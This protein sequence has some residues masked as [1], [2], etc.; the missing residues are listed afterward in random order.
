MQRL[1]GGEHFTLRTI[2]NFIVRL[3]SKIEENAD[4]PV[5]LETVRGS[6]TASIRDVLPKLQNR[7]V[8]VATLVLLGTC[9]RAYR[10]AS[11]RP[12]ACTYGPPSGTA[13]AAAPAGGGLL[14]LRALAQPP[15]IVA[16][17]P[18]DGRE[19]PRSHRTSRLSPALP[20]A[21]STRRCR[22]RA[23]ADRTGCW[24]QTCGWAW[25]LVT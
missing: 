17:A 19:L 18:F 24:H 7:S 15:L 12:L 8:A 23:K 4:T 22:P 6:D 13:L 3:R 21:W 20:P 14:P 10:D 1:W 9:V 25:R 11:F 5:H 2:D 16:T